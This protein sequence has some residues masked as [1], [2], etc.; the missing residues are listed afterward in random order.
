MSAHSAG[1]V[2]RWRVLRR[3]IEIQRITAEYGLQ[4]FV[5][6]GRLERRLAWLRWVSPW[7]WWVQP[8]AGPR[9]ERLRLALETLGH[10]AHLAHQARGHLNR[11]D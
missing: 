7:T 4:E 11:V 8:H 9:A 5:A 2:S 3:L 6:G 10:V 1:K